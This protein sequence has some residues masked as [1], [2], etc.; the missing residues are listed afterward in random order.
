[1]RDRRIVYTNGFEDGVGGTM[2]LGNAH[3]KMVITTTFDEV[4]G[5]TTITVSTLFPTIAARAEFLGM[6]ML[7]GMSSGLDQLEQVATALAR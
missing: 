7:E 2:Q 3:E 6:G 4:D 1:M 5:V